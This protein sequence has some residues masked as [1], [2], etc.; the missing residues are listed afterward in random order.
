MGMSTVAYFCT[1]TN[2]NSNQQLALFICSDVCAENAKKGEI[3]DGEV[4]GTVY[5]TE[6]TGGE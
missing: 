4:C 1:K 5:A 3:L 6:G 2:M